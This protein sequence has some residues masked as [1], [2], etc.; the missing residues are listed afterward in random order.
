MTK[1]LI[2]A[3]P[4]ALASTLAFADGDFARMDANADGKVSRDE[5]GRQPIVTARFDKLDRDH[6]GMLTLPEF[7]AF[8]IDAVRKASQPAAPDAVAKP[9]P[10]K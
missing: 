6:N 2:A 10:A 7:A 8:E 5:A 9:P 1:T 4:L 3:L